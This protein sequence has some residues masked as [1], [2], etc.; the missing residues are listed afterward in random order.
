MK[1]KYYMKIRVSISFA[2]LLTAIIV[3]GF[4]SA[5]VG[6]NTGSNPAP[7]STPTVPMKNS[8]IKLPKTGQIDCYDP[9]GNIFTCANTGQDGELQKG[10]AWPSPR[11]TANNDTTITDNLTGLFWAPNGNLITTRDSN[12]EKQGK[13]FAGAIT[14]QHALDYMAKLNAENY[15]GHN[16]WRLPN[17]KEMRSLINYVQ[18]NTAAWLNSQ[19][20]TNAQ[21]GDFYWTSTSC[22]ND[23]Y[24]AWVVDMDHGNM[25]YFDKAKS[26]QVWP[27]RTATS[28]AIKLPKTGQTHCYDTSGNIISCTN[29]GQDGD[30]QK[31][32]AW[33]SPRFVANADTSITDNL[34]GLVWAPNG[35]LMTTRDS[36]W[37]K[38][39]KAFDGAVTWQHA[40]DYVAKL[41]AENYLGH[42]DWRLPN[43]KEMR[44]LINHGQPNTA[45]WLNSQGF[46][47][48]QSGDFYWTSTSYIID[49]AKAWIVDMEL[50]NVNYFIKSNI[51]YVWPVRG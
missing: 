31:G 42:S 32:V 48:A 34:T 6:E 27:V 14:W 51:H 7:A 19:G 1:G 17:I 44:S 13:V 16:D 46:T 26:H 35:N 4:V 12:W 18:P 39:S 3:I 49:A 5:S 20:F 45:A 9:S 8:A 33:P 2:I 21:S 23:G 47:N 50:G 28:S 24:R 43:I 22:S 41:N 29:S 15:L 38:Q 25:N 30:L 40:L 37:E 36:K 11:F 10:V